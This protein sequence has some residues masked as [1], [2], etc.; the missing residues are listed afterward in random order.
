[1]KE[2]GMKFLCFMTFILAIVLLNAVYAQQSGDYYAAGNKLFRDGEYEKALEQYTRAIQLDPRNANYYASRGAAYGKLDLYVEGL[3]ELKKAVSVNP[4]VEEPYFLI[5]SFFAEL[6]GIDDALLY[7]SERNKVTPNNAV[8][9]VNLGY[10]YYRKGEL[11]TATAEMRK[12]IEIDSVYP[13]AYSGLGV[14]YLSDN[15][16]SK[17]RAAFEKALAIRPDYPEAHLYLGIIY[18]RA[19]KESESKEEIEKAYAL[20]PQLKTV[21]LAGTLPIRGRKSAIPILSLLPVDF[22]RGVDVGYRNIKL[23]LGIG[24]TNIESENWYTL[25]THPEIDY[26]YFGAKTSL[27]FLMNGQGRLRETDLEYTKILQYVRLG[28]AGKPFYL[29]GG[30]INDYTLGYGS[31]VHSYM[32]Q[33]DES[34]RRIGALLAVKSPLANFDGMLNDIQKPDVFAGR[35]GFK[36]FQNLELGA[37][38]AMDV[39]QD[40]NNETEDDAVTIYGGDITLNFSF[41]HS[42]QAGLVSDIAQIDGYGMGALSGL[43]L[44]IQGSNITSPK[45]SLFA[46]YVYNGSVYESRIFNAFYEKEKQ[47][48]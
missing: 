4:K 40:G 27:E 3:E 23:N 44:L 48:Y 41:S 36:L 22:Q 28:S 39:N 12:A 19:G 24:I 5:E 11:E 34:N 29:L 26:P 33:S 21:D 31:V 1:M 30:K 2:R 43:L 25:T 16:D 38:I 9:H 13:L 46:A 37:S 17:A 6:E 10:I 45:L 20:K 18:R 7:F 15:K 32:N 42:M 47:L 35:A 8:I 14:V